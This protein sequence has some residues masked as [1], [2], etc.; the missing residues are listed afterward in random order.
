LVE[1][2]PAQVRWFI[3]DAG[4]I[5]DIDY[6]AAQTIRD[7]FEELGRHDV[8]VVFA[9]VSSYLRSD[10]DR[11]GVTAA[12]GETRIFTTLH[13]AIAAARGG[14]LEAQAEEPQSEV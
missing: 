10:L 7:L 13:E 2:A 3:V 4:A 5:T 1:R 12:V 8:G 9:R 6:S 11:H 14:G